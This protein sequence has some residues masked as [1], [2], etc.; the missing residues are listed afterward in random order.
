MTATAAQAPTRTPGQPPVPAQDPGIV[1][2]WRPRVAVETTIDLAA[3]EVAA[4]ALLTALGQRLD[5]PHMTETP[6]RMAAA[7]AELLE[8]APF[9]FTTF[10]NT[11]GYDELV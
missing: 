11:E 10:P 5:S 6:R 2:P 9:E 4:T 3:A 7:Y 1:L 8:P